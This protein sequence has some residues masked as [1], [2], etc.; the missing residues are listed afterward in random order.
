MDKTKEK[1]IKKLKKLRTMSMDESDVNNRE[2][3]HVKADWLLLDYINDKEV[4]ASFA[5]ILKWYA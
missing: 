1:L 3:A 2:N 5:S 4:S